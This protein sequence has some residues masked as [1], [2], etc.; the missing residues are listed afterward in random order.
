MNCK[1]CGIIN[2]NGYFDS[3]LTF[4]NVAVTEGFMKQEHKNML[5]NDVSPEGILEQLYNY[6]AP[7]IEKWAGAKPRI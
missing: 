1:P 7:V 4:F 5:L 2:V 3:L 6:K